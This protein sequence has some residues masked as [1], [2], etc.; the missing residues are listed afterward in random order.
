MAYLDLRIIDR[1][2]LAEV[3]PHVK[4]ASALHAPHSAIVDY[5]KIAATYGAIFQNAGGELRLNSELIGCSRSDAGRASVDYE[6]LGRNWMQN[7]L[8]TVLDC[9]RM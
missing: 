2:E 7:L 9:I 4:G 1:D 8:S 6:I 3:E 5:K